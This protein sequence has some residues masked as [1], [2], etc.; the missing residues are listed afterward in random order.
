MTPDPPE[1]APVLPPDEE[2]SLRERM[3]DARGHLPTDE[4]VAMI[5]VDQ[6]A[7]RD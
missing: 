1:D 7:P 4:E 2:E 5:G 6:A 3:E